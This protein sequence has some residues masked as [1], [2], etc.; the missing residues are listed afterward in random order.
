MIHTCHGLLS[1]LRLS[2]SDT[3]KHESASSLSDTVVDN[4]RTGTWVADQ[5]SLTIAS[6]SLIP[7]STVDFIKKRR[8]KL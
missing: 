5:R 7:D 2:L 3:L 8:F 4:T 6:S 1:W